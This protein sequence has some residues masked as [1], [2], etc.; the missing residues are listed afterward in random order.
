MTNYT[1]FENY[2]KETNPTK[3]IPTPKSYNTIIVYIYTLYSKIPRQAK[4]KHV[5]WISAKMLQKLYKRYNQIIDYLIYTGSITLHRK[6]YQLK[7]ICNHYWIN[8]NKLEALIDKAT[9]FSPDNLS[10]GFLDIVA[11][12]DIITAQALFTNRQKRLHA[13]TAK[14]TGATQFDTQLVQ[15]RSARSRYIE[16]TTELRTYDWFKHTPS[17]FLNT[18]KLNNKSFIEI[19]VANAQIAFALNLMNN[20]DL[21]IENDLLQS[22]RNGNIYNKLA[23]NLGIHKSEAKSILL[24]MINAKVLKSGDYK[25]DDISYHDSKVAMKLKYSKFLS[26]MLI[27]RKTMD[28]R[29]AYMAHENKTFRTGYQTSLE[30]QNKAL[31]LT[32]DKHDAWIGNKDGLE[33]LY[34]W[35]KD[36]KLFMNQSYH[37]TIH[38]STETTID[39]SYTELLELL[40]N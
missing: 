14:I 37:V 39:V 36:N 15:L 24:I 8:L 30:L 10:K 25:T 28:L 27:L 9:P 12:A 4:L 2:Y 18:H 35:G 31:D 32:W 29:L 6:A 19:D 1:H 33:G 20:M 23:N 40:K 7:G 22:A 21:P 5:A 34:T 3:H 26:S 17:S 11:S 16:H 38:G 13:F